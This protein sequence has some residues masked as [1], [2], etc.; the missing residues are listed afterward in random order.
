MNYILLILAFASILAS[1]GS[2]EK[3]IDSQTPESLV[4][5]ENGDFKPKPTVPY[6]PKQDVFKVDDSVVV[7]TA[8]ESADRIPTA[9]LE[10]LEV[11]PDPINAAIGHCYRKQFDQA[12]VVFDRSYERYRTH[13]SYWNQI[14][15]CYLLQEN[16]RKALLY[17]N[18]A[19]GID[20]NYA[21]A[22]NN[23]GVL[24]WRQ[25]KDQ[26]AIEAFEKASK[27]NS[28]SMTPIFNLAQLYLQ[29]GFVD[30][31][32]KL[33]SAL[34]RQG[35]NDMDVLS[36]LASCY[37]MMGNPQSSVAYFDQVDD[38]YLKRPDVSLNYAYALHLVG[39]RS[40]AKDV[41]KKLSAKDLVD[42]SNY[43]MRVKKLVED[44]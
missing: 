30:Q 3:K 16:Y 31:A 14:G 28:F 9:K 6:I 27:V 11:D 42:Y 12:F 40:D 4:G 2:S 38:S 35:R 32:F 37:L 7:S 25:G 5:I 23:F 20:S 21:P 39:R 33:L 10:K 13:P 22:I 43:Y 44:K 36:S 18:K 24:Y 8:R 26:L 15:T 29:Y 17:Y 19:L 41:L 1:C 34:H